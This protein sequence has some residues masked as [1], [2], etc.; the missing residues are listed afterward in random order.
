MTGAPM[1]FIRHG[2]TDWNREARLQGQQ[3]IAL[4]ALGRRQAARNGRI[5]PLLLGSAQWRF[6]ASPLGRAT[7]TMM[8]ALE[9]AGI[10]DTEF[11]IDDRLKEISFG[12]WE[13]LTLADVAEKDPNGGKGR[14]AD[15]WGF[16]PPGGESYAD[17]CERIGG[18][19]ADQHRP[20]VVVGHGGVLRVL[21]HRLG[22]VAAAEAPLLA[23]P[24]DRITVF[25]RGR[26]IAI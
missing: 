19:L 7:E 3:D 26:V 25:A 17:L 23:A 24:Q 20:A 14:D 12:R 22:G 18:W 16:V 21:H 13:G 8:I 9:A 4:N 11:D 10:A 5:L 15:K 1:I 2:E 6:I